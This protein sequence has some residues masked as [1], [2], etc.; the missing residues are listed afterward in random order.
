MVD[1]IKASQQR[2]KP[3]I[4]EFQRMLPPLADAMQKLDSLTR[5]ARTKATN[6]HKA[7]TECLQ[8]FTWITYDASSGDARRPRVVFACVC[9]CAMTVSTL[10]CTRPYTGCATHH[11]FT[12]TGHVVQAVV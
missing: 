12:G 9:S 11:P 6:H 10:R 7:I 4:D 3:A 1:V 8:G 5:G 2:A